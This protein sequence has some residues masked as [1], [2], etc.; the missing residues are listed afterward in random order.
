MHLRLDMD[1]QAAGQEGSAQ[2]QIFI[3]DLKNDLAN[4]AAAP[5]TGVCVCVFVCVCVCVA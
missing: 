3:K 4:A 2:R 1:F 5:A